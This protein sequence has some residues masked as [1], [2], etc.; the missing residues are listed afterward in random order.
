MQ[1][2]VHSIRLIGPD[3]DPMVFFVCLSDNWLK[4]S[5]FRSQT[6]KRPHSLVPPLVSDGA[7]LTDKVE[8]WH[9]RRFLRASISSSSSLKSGDELMTGGDF[10]LA[11]RRPG[12][13]TGNRSF[14]RPGNQVFKN[15]SMATRTVVIANLSKVT[16]T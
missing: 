15:S 4:S 5:D 9:L 2:W 10:S 6:Q 14:L 8:A 13:L 12:T 7:S 11:E 3:P 1:E 16:S